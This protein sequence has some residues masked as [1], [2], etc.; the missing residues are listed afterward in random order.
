MLVGIPKDELDGLL[1][2]AAGSHPAVFLMAL[3]RSGAD[4]IHRPGGPA[5]EPICSSNTMLIAAEHTGRRCFTMEQDP[6]YCDVAVRRWQM[7]RSKVT[8]SMSRLV[9]QQENLNLS[10]Q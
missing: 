10:A 3:G 5:F 7:T 6:V 9:G 8:K 2:G 4:I 1:R